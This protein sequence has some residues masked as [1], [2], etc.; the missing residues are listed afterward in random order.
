[1]S[2]QLRSWIKKLGESLRGSNAR[3]LA[4]NGLLRRGPRSS[5]SK[6]A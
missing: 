6:I 2:Y 5:S 4:G 1:M 3:V